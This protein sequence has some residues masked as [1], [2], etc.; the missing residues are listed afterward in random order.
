MQK[1]FGIPQNRERL[2][3]ISIRQDIAKS[4]FVFPQSVPLVWKLKDL[5]VDKVEEKYYLSEKAIRKIN[6]KK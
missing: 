3:I 1:I 4:N 2:F 6:K 5:L